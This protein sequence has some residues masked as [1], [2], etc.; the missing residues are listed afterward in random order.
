M[1]QPINKFILHNATTDDIRAAV[2]HYYM[3]HAEMFQGDA[4]DD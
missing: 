3:T 1:I 2:A 4:H